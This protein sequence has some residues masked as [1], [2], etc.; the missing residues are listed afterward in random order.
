MY[1][2][3]IIRKEAHTM[4]LSAREAAL[5]ALTAYRRSGAWSESWLR[6]LFDR[7]KTDS[8]DR[9]LA[10]ALACGVLQNRL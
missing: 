4:P 10:T 7:E 9:A 8:R 6:A 1:E 3:R 2:A 5:A